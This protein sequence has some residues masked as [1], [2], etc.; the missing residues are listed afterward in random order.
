MSKTALITGASRGIGAAIAEALAAD[1]Y[2]L[3]LCCRENHTLLSSVALDLGI[4]YSV[5]ARPLIGDVGD[6]SFS[7]KVLS[8]IPTPDLL[9]NNAGIAHFALLQ[10]TRNEDWK[11]L[12]QVNLNGPFYFSRAVVPGMIARQSGRIINISS[13]WGERGASMEVAYSASK[14]ALNAF[15]RALARELAPSGIAVNALACGYIDTEM[16]A[17]LSEDEKKALEDDIPA[18]RAGRPEEVARCVSL[19]AQCPVYLTGQVITVDGG[20]T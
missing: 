20:W 16:N 10:D 14:G 19:L 13:V 18:G 4:R 8:E 1:G 7:E 17:R 15:T 9:V 5:T 12:M 11:R 3:Y 6:P 2:D